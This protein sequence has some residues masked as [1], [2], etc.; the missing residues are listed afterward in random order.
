[1]SVLS[2]RCELFD[3]LAVWVNQN[4]LNTWQIGHV[5]ALKDEV[6]AFLKDALQEGKDLLVVTDDI[7]KVMDV[8]PQSTILWNATL[9]EYRRAVILAFH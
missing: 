8:F 9:I 2:S 6:E 4:Q 3:E 1:M 7:R 5:D